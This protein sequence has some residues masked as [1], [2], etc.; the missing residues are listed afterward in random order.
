MEQLKN[1]FN[2][3]NRQFID[4]PTKN[5]SASDRKQI[6]DYL[7]NDEF[8]F[9]FVSG[10]NREYDQIDGDILTVYPGS[11]YDGEYFWTYSEAVYVAKHNLTIS[12][13]FM[14]RVRKFYSDGNTVKKLKVDWSNSD[15]LFRKVPTLQDKSS[16]VPEPHCDDGQIGTPIA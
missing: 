2:G 14:E 15:N 12:D 13:A 9:I 11:G 8:E 5:Y 10:N 16:S 3:N 6:L 1:I 7:F 4:I